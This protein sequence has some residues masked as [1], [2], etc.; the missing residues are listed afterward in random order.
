[1][2]HRVGSVG[3][4]SPLGIKGDIH[5]YF[6]GVK[7]PPSGQALVLE[8]AGKAVAGLGRCCRCCDGGL[9]A[10]ILDGSNT[11]PT[12]G[13]KVNVIGI[14][15]VVEL[16][17]QAAVLFNNAAG[18][19]AFVFFV[20]VKAFIVPGLRGSGRT[21]VTIMI[22]RLVIGVAHTRYILPVVL[23]LVYGFKKFPRLSRTAVPFV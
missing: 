19:P 8:P 9:V 20:F 23:H 17:N 12:V 15:V 21:V 1:M 6:I 18:Y 2:L 10:N 3:V 13:I 16:Q 5:G 14:P 7:N 22:S 4:R 11:I